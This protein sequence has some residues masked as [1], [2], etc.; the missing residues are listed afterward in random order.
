MDKFAT[1]LEN[2]MAFLLGNKLKPSLVTNEAVLHLKKAKNLLENAS[3]L[4]D[5]C[6]VDLVAEACKVN[7]IIKRATSGDELIDI[8]LSKP[9]VDKNT[10]S[11]DISYQY[12]ST[13]YGEG[14]GSVLLQASLDPKIL[15][16][17]I[18][19]NIGIGI[20]PELLSVGS[21]RKREEILQ[22]SINSLDLSNIA[23]E[24]VETL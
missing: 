5:F 24:I 18:K 9:I 2:N 15:E 1:Q 19:R 3:L 10:G 8:S 7:N 22:K 4:S 6:E 11:I 21:F 14:D 12:S 20:G 23:N 16:S 13:V 17:S